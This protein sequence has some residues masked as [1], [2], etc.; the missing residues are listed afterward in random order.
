MSI[1]A[2][3]V[4]RFKAPALPLPG[5]EYNRTYFDE[6]LKVLRLYF[7]QLDQLLGAIVAAQPVNVQFFGSA[8]DAFG[9]ARF[10]QPY[11]L[12]DSQNRYAQNG[13]FDTELTGSGT[14]TYVANESTVEMETTTASGDK[15]IAQTKRSFAYQPGK[16]LLVLSTFAM[17]AA[18]EE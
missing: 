1:W 7:N 4:K 8:L 6:L 18:Q 5:P 10:S 3:I 16:S 11:T 12:F 2:N 14:S 9:R 15:V 17:S 13:Y